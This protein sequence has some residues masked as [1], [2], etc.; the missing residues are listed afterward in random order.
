MS[1]GG[2]SQLCSFNQT[3]LVLVSL[4]LAASDESSNARIACAR[5]SDSAGGAYRSE[6]EKKKKRRESCGWEKGGIN[7]SLLSPSSF[8][9]LFPL[10]LFM[11][12]YNSKYQSKG[13][14]YILHLLAFAA[15]RPSKFMYI[16]RQ[17]PGFGKAMKKVREAGFS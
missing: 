9:P 14:I 13:P 3:A 8:L 1:R 16:G 7:P 17:K 2:C 11:L 5:C 4:F 10:P 15:I 6:R 12:S